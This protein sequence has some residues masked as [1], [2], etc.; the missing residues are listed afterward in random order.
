MNASKA[1]LIITLFSCMGQGKKHYS[2][3]SIEKILELLR[4]YHKIE[5]KRRWVF[6]CLLDLLNGG[7]ITRKQRYVRQGGGLIRQIPSMITFT[8]KGAKYLVSRRVSGAVGLL[9]SI[10]SWVTGKDRRWPHGADVIP[11]PSQGKKKTNQRELT[12]LLNNI[13]GTI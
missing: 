9:K 6:R 2:V 13:T 8:L 7:Y 1:S 5:I 10:L 11:P 3:V 12:K 4:K